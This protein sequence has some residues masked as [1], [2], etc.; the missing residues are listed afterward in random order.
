[1]AQV[2]RRIHASLNPQYRILFTQPERFA[3]RETFPR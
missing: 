1:L 3:W 2:R